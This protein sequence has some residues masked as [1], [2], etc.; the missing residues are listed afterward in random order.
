MSITTHLFPATPPSAARRGCSWVS[1]REK[2][3]DYV[4]H[5][6]G[7]IMT[8][9]QTQTRTNQTN[10]RTLAT[11]RQGHHLCFLLLMLDSSR[12]DPSASFSCG[13]PSDIWGGQAAAPSL[14]F[15]LQQLVCSRFL[16]FGPKKSWLLRLRCVSLQVVF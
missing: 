4:A 8:N 3:M 6:Q 1:V 14:T 15:V 12:R 2:A 16:L 10:L 9:A 5:K 11:L 13:G 7:S